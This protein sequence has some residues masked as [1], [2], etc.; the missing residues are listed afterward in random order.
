MYKRQVDQLPPVGAGNVLSE[1]IAGGRIDVI[2]LDKVLRQAQKSRI[3]TNAPVSYT[4]L[5][6]VRE[7][8]LRFW[9]RQLQNGY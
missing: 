2:S 6:G 4:H 3:V 8:N 9:Q 5:P 1:L 7:A